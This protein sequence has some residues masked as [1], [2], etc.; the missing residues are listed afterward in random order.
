VARLVMTGYV[1]AARSLSA[2]LGL[3][4]LPAGVRVLAVVGLAGGRADDLLDVVEQALPP[5]RRQVLAIGGS[6]DLW[7][8][9]PDEEVEAALRA[10][11]RFTASAARQSRAVVSALASLRQVARLTGVMEQA[12]TV[13]QPGQLRDL[14][15]RG[16]GILG[17]DLLDQLDLG[18]IVN[19]QRADLVR[20]VVAYLRHRGHWEEAARD[21]G[22][23]RNTL[24]HR[25]AT[26]GRV[27]GAD[28]D[29]P[30]VASRLWLALRAAGLA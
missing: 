27:L 25:M 8:L 17:G 15:E 20:S 28:L 22:I 7:V 9:L 29:D 3:A 30:D 6:E 12:L 11:R 23:H 26:A 13:Q 18:P 2:D 21:L 10:V 19:Y 4:A 1:D 14:A 24:R 5:H 16:P